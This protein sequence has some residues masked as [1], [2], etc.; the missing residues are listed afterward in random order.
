MNHRP[1]FIAVM[2]LV[3]V[4]F[5]LGYGFG[6]AYAAEPLS[7]PEIG[8]EPGF[9]ESYDEAIAY[10]SQVPGVPSMEETCGPP[11]QMFLTNHDPLH[12][13][14]WGIH[15]RGDEPCRIWIERDYLNHTEAFPDWMRDAER[16]FAVIHEIGHTL[17][18]TH[19]FD[20]DPHNIMNPSASMP[21]AC[22]EA[23]LSPSEGE[24]VC[25]PAWVLSG[26]YR[27][28]TLFADGKR[29]SARR[30]FKRWAKTHP[31]QARKALRSA[32]ICLDKYEA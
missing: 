12:A 24:R 3:F 18:L 19:E 15:R 26:P 4:A 25:F 14:A 1:A 20:G 28:F 32:A 31:G 17:G 11:P 21:E 30:A 10:W 22:I 2:A 6:Q 5:F 13:A 8:T 7:G 9:Y 16:C 23:Y 29:P 27:A